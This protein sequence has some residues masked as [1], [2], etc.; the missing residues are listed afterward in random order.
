M[1]FIG[2]ENDEDEYPDEKHECPKCGDIYFIN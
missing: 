1:I 2:F